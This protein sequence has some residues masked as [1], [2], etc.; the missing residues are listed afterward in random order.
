MKRYRQI[1]YAL[2]G[3]L[4]LVI[5]ML[6]FQVYESGVEG[7]RICKQKAESSLKSARGRQAASY[8]AGGRRDGGSSRFD[9]GRKTIDC[10]TNAKFE[11]SLSVFG[12]QSGFQSFE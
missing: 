2:G 11:D 10:F 4:L 6:A 3:S 7:R 5:G 12:G 1:L 8:S 9:K